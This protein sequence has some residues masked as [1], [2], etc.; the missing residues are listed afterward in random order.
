MAEED[1]ARMGTKLSAPADFDG[2]KASRHCTDIFC[3]LLLVCTWI[4]MT[5]LGIYAIR[6]GDYRVVVYPLDYDGNICGTKKGKIDMTDYPKLVYINALSGG[7][8]VKECPEISNLVDIHT[9]VTYGGIYQGQNAS[10]PKDYI[11]IANYSTSDNVLYCD[12]SLCPT[13]PSTNWKS[14]GINEGYGFAFYAL[15]TI[16]V[17]ELRCI[18][19]PKAEDK[20]EE[21][22]DMSDP[23]DFLLNNTVTNTASDIISDLYGDLYT[24]RKYIFYFGFGLAMVS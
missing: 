3:M 17:G 15:D 4:A 19:N 21:L 16:E 8:C 12:E 18:A 20:L 5:A 1:E 23:F 24:A 14:K 11:S 2:P 13:D 22:V 10:L 7:V 9:F 6:N